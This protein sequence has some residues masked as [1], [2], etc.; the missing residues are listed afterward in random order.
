N[1]SDLIA[2]EEPFGQEVAK[3]QRNCSVHFCS[4]V[5]G[6]GLK[7]FEASVFKP[8]K[9]YIMIGSSGAGKSSLLNLFMQGHL[10]PVNAIS[11]FNSKGRHTTTRRD[12]F[13]LPNR[14]LLIDT[15]GM[16]EFGLSFSEEDS[17]NDLFP[18][19]AKLASAC[20]F[21]DCAHMHET[22]CA[23]LEAV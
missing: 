1:K 17:S 23:V 6:E 7:E 21:S 11:D 3:L 13:L 18:A 2:D 14:S 15:P 9:T 20:R 5:T 4:V 22:G 16:R 8:G 12:L 10:Q 19:I